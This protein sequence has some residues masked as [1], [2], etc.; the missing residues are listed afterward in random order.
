MDTCI[1]LGEGT[2]RGCPG[3][4]PQGTQKG[5]GAEGNLLHQAKGPGN[6]LEQSQSKVPKNPAPDMLKSGTSQDNFIN[7][8]NVSNSF[9]TI[10]PIYN[11]LKILL[12]QH[13]I[14][15]RGKALW[16]WPWQELFLLLKRQ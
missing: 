7:S 2:A 12:S 14:Q 1:A 15:G 3:H 13:N 4:W 5:A 16:L 6:P 8:F 9:P 11:F 10:P